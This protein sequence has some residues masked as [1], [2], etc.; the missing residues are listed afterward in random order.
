M[1]RAGSFEFQTRHLLVIA[2]LALAF[3]SALIMR[4]YPV[5]YGFYLN[6]FD[7]YFD[8]RATKYIVDNGLDAYWN[9]HDTM[10]WYPEGRDIPATSQSGLHITTAVL[11][12]AFGGGSD[13][14]DFTIVFPA[15]IGSLT[16]IVIFALVRVL[17]NTSAGL[18]SALLFAFSPAIIQR[19]NLG[20]FKSEPLG[21]FFGI[22]AAYLFIS[23]IKHK[24]IKYAIPKA[25]AGGLIL[26]LANASWGGIQYFSIPI[27]I[28]FI[29]LPFFRRDLTIPMYVAIAFTVFTLISAAAFP[30]P[31]MSFVL[32]LPGLGMIGS[33]IFL[34]IAH[35]L[36]RFSRSQVQLRNTAFLLIA[37]VAASVGVIATEAY[38]SPSFRYLNAV[39]P[40][41]SSQN[42]LV[43]SVAE[44]FTPTV[45]D[46][47]VDF[48]VLI[49]FAGLGAWLA[50]RRRDD[51]SI[52]ALII[53]ITGVYVSA[54][55]ARLLVFA[56]LGIIVLAGLGL[57][58]VTRSIMAHRQAT[59]T[60]SVTQRPTAATRE[61]R[62]KIEF[63]G[64]GH[65]AS[66][67]AVR[68]AYTVVII[69]MLSIPMFFP[70]NS[71]WLSS[72]D[73][74]AAIANGGTGFRTQTNDWTDALNWIEQNT[75]PD[76]VIASWW[77]Y[78]YWI[79]TLGNRT[80]LAD[81]ATINSTRI[82]TIAKMLIS[83]E[84][85]GLKIAQDLQ[86]DYILV[87]TVA[88]VRFLGQTNNTETGATEQVPI[89]TLGQGG[90]ESKKQWFMRIGGFDES[91]YIESDGFTPT[92]EFWN[93]T[94]LGKL[95]P[96]EPSSYVQLSD[97]RVASQPQPE[98]E[99]GLTGL[100]TQHIKY[101]TDG[102]S[103]Q[104]LHLVYASP[105]FEN[106]ENIMFGVFIYKVNHD[107]VPNPQ[108]DPYA[109]PEPTTANMTT[110]N[111]IAIINTTQGPI[112]IE[113]F[114]KEAPKHVDNF[115]KLA[116]EGFYDGTLF[117]R[118]VPGFVIQ[119]GDPNTK[120]DDSDRSTWGQGGPG[121]T[122]NA[123]FNDIPHTR[124]I[125]SMARAQDPNSAGS[126]FFIV[127]DDNEN[128][129]A[130]DGKYTVFGKVISGMDVVDKIAALQTTMVGQTPQPA[131]PEEARIISISIRES[132]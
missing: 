125:V 37:F 98:W 20:W 82:E 75:E 71:N 63:A 41:L 90:D 40:F 130:L 74:P 79:T 45:A 13:L 28:F 116:N 126:Q 95:F 8:Y 50:F 69:M 17:G 101:P 118:I 77:D 68:I 27:A 2:V 31:G 114:P 12:S 92:P 24:E 30:R 91:K 16:V 57:Y 97:G 51:M 66:G 38:L 19:G 131:N 7:P 127:L 25:V 58:E 86:A 106:E 49:M 104:P 34:V 48:S 52:F 43:E 64:R 100:Y 6:E 62:R 87:Y 107:Y 96:F 129:R 111:E 81:N 93:N 44:H 53:G 123:E 115:I 33:T 110:S 94:L 122:V 112:E 5:K 15:V 3:T 120:G 54:T 124:G 47:F 4:F 32:G 128:T 42:A 70:S 65:P 39:F 78:G 108:G 88:Q 10:S 36:K 121:Y 89:Y 119:G 80:T 73:S 67:Q 72:A 132:K 9:W 18:F 23:A 102:G 21:L 1:F 46:Y 59:A 55:F 83:D 11:Y 85:A 113:F 109:E 61:E 84:Q 103:D 14:L 56:S 29:A 99:P 26:G 22:L 105:S 35:F 60:P 117:H 76:A